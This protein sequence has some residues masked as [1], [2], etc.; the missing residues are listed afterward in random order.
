[1]REEPSNHGVCKKEVTFIDLRM[2]TATEE[3]EQ[4]MN[5]FKPTEFYTLIN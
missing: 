5:I 2:K 4:S 1:M 3:R